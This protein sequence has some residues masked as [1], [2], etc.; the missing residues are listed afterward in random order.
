MIIRNNSVFSLDL[1][2]AVPPTSDIK[3]STRTTKNSTSL[4]NSKI[5]EST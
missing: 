4:K 2:A 3:Y 5:Y 1:P